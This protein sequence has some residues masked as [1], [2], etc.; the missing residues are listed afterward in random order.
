ML[1]V[2]KNAGAFKMY[3]NMKRLFLM[4]LMLCAMMIKTPKKKY[5]EG[6]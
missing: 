1:S 3:V 2:C 4:F 5:G 6:W